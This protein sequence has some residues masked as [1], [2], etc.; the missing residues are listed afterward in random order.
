M[1]RKPTLSETIPLILLTI[2]ALVILALF[3]IN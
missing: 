2:A 1:D 3:I